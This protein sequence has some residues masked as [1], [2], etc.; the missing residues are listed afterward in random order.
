MGYC[1]NCSKFD[2]QSW[3]ALKECEAQTRY[4]PCFQ[5]IDGANSGC[6]FCTFLVESFLDEYPDETKEVLLGGMVMLKPLREP[7]YRE[8]AMAITDFVVT[9]PH[10]DEKK[11]LSIQFVAT[12]E[13]GQ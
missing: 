3:A 2:I 9:L 7:L 13:Q 8:T 10:W 4:I 6:E 12:A 11:S 1:Q 5:I